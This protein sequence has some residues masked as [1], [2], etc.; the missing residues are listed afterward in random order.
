MFE[1][2]SVAREF[3]VAV[4]PLVAQIELRDKSLADQLRRAATSAALNTAEG[5][6]RDGRDRAARYRIAAGEC[7]EAATAVQVAVDWGY[8][9]TAAAAPALVL[10]DRVRA[11]LWRL[12]HPRR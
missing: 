5:G 4:R 10:A 3:I 9:P 2:L 1:A 7:A 8:V 11:M 12:R 6:R